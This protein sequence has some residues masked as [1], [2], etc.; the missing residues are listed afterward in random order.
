MVTDAWRKRKTGWKF[1]VVRSI[2][3]ST[4]TFFQVWGQ[5]FHRR[6]VTLDTVLTQKFVSFACATTQM[7]PFPFMVVFSISKSLYLKKTSK[8]KKKKKRKWKI[9]PPSPSCAVMITLET[10][11]CRRKTPSFIEFKS[12]T[13][14][15]W[16]KCGFYS[17]VLFRPEHQV[18]GIRAVWS[19][20]KHCFLYFS[21]ALLGLAWL[22][23]TVFFFRLAWKTQLMFADVL[24]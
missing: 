15:V 20:K 19:C 21:E 23:T 11:K 17:I 13:T 16:R 7:L 2:V 18:W 6:N 1:K 22:W 8:V 10:K 3:D 9:T 5:N 4:S 12:V 24:V 14:C